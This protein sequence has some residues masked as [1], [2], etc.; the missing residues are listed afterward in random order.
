[1]KITRVSE[2]TAFKNPHKIQA[3]KIFGSPDAE[4]IHM[5]LTPSE[6]LISHITPVDVF[7]YVLEGE[8]TIEIG[9]EREK[10]SAD[11]IIE[12]P[13]NIPH[14][15]YNESETTARFLVVKLPKSK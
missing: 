9:D 7:F 13:A 15:V 2:E 8:P 4:V 10:V 1:M 14:C 5:T 12:S 6:H 11:S 3:K